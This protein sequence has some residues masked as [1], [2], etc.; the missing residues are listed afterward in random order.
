MDSEI[1]WWDTEYVSSRSYSKEFLIYIPAPPHCEDVGVWR[2]SYPSMEI[3]ES[4]FLSYNLVSVTH[5]TSN[6]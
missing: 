5:M 4:E 3:L 6:G 2:K 1:L